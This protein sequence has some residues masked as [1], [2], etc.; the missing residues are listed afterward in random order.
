MQS[1]H[2]H[3]DGRGRLLCPL[4]AAVTAESRVIFREASTRRRKWRAPDQL[5]GPGVSCC[6]RHSAIPLAWS[7]APLGGFGVQVTVILSALLTQRFMM[8]G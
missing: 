4:E 6:G 1:G 8:P 7:P 2:T 3:R 5:P